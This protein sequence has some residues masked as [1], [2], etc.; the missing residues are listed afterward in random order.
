MHAALNCCSLSAGKKVVRWPCPCSSGAGNVET[1]GWMGML[2]LPQEQENLLN[3]VCCRG[4]EQFC[5]QIFASR[6]PSWGKLSSLVL[7]HIQSRSCFRDLAGACWDTG[8]RQSHPE[9]GL[10]PTALGTRAKRSPGET[11]LTRAWHC[12]QR[13][14]AAGSVASKR[15]D[16]KWRGSCPGA[17]DTHL[18][19]HISTQH[20]R[21]GRP[22][23]A[24]TAE[25]AISVVTEEPKRHLA[26]L[27]WQ[28]SKVYGKFSYFTSL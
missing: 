19:F 21:S 2:C 27:Q 3:R 28:R 26:H 17:P 13:T 9:V 24:A 5:L 1:L 20:A 22:A 14:A 4:N 25:N 15:E 16:G 11:W 8:C 7:V 23:Q 12:Q 18:T 6:S 10:C